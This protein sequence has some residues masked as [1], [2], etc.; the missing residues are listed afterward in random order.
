M[1]SHAANAPLQH[2]EPRAG[3]QSTPAAK[4]TL[5]TETNLAQLFRART[6][7]FGDMTRW[8]QRF[9]QEWRSATYRENQRLVNRVMCG[10]DA[11]GIRRGDA[12]GI[13]SGRSEERRVGKECRSRGW[14]GH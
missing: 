1:S 6:A 11:L 10:L 4:E 5:A 7:R 8:R 13:L 2:D 9:G 14:R 12:V 3:V